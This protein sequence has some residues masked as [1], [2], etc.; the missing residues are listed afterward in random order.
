MRDA[1][2]Q[3]G[4]NDLEL[5]PENGG[6]KPNGKN[7]HKSWTHFMGEEFEDF[8]DAF[9]ELEAY[10]AASGEQDFNLDAVLKMRSYFS[11]EAD[12][13]EGLKH[14]RVGYFKWIHRHLGEC[15]A[16]VR[17]DRHADRVHRIA[18]DVKKAF[19]KLMESQ[20]RNF[21]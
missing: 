19:E 14:L 10:I 12:Q 7:S 4:Y 13:S 6:P 9:D 18:K 1:Y 17:D 15:R 3:C 11:P 16:E 2:T 21:Q 8:D 20:S 5:N